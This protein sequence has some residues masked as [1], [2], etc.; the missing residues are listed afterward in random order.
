MAVPPGAAVIGGLWRRIK[1]VALADVAVLVKGVD[2]SLVEGIERVLL[3]ADFG[4]VAYTLLGD[5]ENRLRR[6]ELRTEEDVRRWLV[7]RVAFMLG[8]PGGLE[9]LNFG[10][11]A[12]PAV[13]LLVGVNGVGKTTVA[14]KLAHSLL[15]WGRSVLLAATDTYRAAAAEQMAIWAQRLSVPCVTG[16]LG[17]DPAA[18]AFTA[19]DAAVARG[20]DAVVLDTAGRLHTRSDLVE[21]LKKVHRV[22][23]RKRSGAPHETFLVVDATTG[24]NAVVQAAT[25]TEAVPVTGM[26]V[27]KLDGTAKGGSVVAVKNRL[28]LPIRFLGAGERAG[29]L[30]P[31]VPERFAEQLVEG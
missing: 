12:G 17:G 16:Q 15:Q 10:D 9:R 19:I 27:T 31:F 23:G 1:E 14:A 21:E 29:D 2:P 22:A 24:Q 11:G 26:I 7:K 20:I 5:L 25:F 18:V 3:E 6:G 13:F 30:E 8:E 28:N 4:P